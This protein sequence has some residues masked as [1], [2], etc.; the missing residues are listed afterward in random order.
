MV[1][2]KIKSTSSTYWK[3]NTRILKD[4]DFLENFAAL[5]DV[6]KLKQ[7]DFSDIAEW[8]NVAA[9]PNIKE[10][11]ATF[12]TQRNIRRR[13]TKAFW[14]AYLKI[15]LLDKNWTEV[16]RVKGV[17]VEIMQEDAY[18]YVVRSRYQNNA[19]EEIASIFHANKEIKN[20]SK[21]N[22]QSLKIGN[23]VS[24]DKVAVEEEVIKFFHALFNGHHN[25]DLKD[26]GEPFKAVNS[27]LD[28]FLQDLSALP[29]N[30]RDNLVQDMKSEELEEIV[31]NC[32]RNK[33]PGLDGLSYEFYQGTFSIIKDDLLKI[34][35]CQLNRGTIIESN[36]DGVTRLVP[37]VKGV[38]SVDELRPITLLDCDY[39][40]LSKWFRE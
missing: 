25:T 18:G 35:Q 7:E 31:K 20:A 26:T 16:V 30:E 29:D 12:S 11:C 17:L 24:E 40:I 1:F 10:F 14:L 23:V 32:N 6:L 34:F 22:I 2:S 21:N 36:K 28:S 5:W 27:H 15:A 33:S 39:K 4:E 38:P 3:L 13:D 37:K 19:A 9:K 8:W